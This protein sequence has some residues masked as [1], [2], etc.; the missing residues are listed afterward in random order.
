MPL[1]ADPNAASQTAVAEASADAAVHTQTTTTATVTESIDVGASV[2]DPAPA[3]EAVLQTQGAASEQAVA[4]N[5]TAAAPAT[6]SAKSL[7][8]AAQA[9]ADAGFD[10]GDTDF[11]SFPN[12]VLKDGEF[13]I[14]GINRVFDA[15]KGFDGVITRS[16]RKHAMRVGNDDDAEVAFADNVA[17]FND[18]N[19]EAGKKVQEWRNQGLQPEL[20]EYTE[21]YVLVT[22]IYD[23]EHD[24]SDLVGSLVIAQISPQS[25]GRFAGYTQTQYQKGN[26]MPD[27]YTTHF[28]RGEKVT[29]AKFPFYPWDFRYVRQN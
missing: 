11:T 5:Q 20:K 28:H 8:Q 12:I 1:I 19:T 4:V 7:G 17:E 10:V 13:Q 9:M 2:L 25:R 24:M 27:C 16:K 14:S 23:D 21:A 6:T 29:S 3:A 22:A 18:P 15:K 26:G